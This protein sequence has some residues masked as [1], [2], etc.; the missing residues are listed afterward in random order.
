MFSGRWKENLQEVVELKELSPKTFQY[1]LSFIYSN[2]IEVSTDLDITEVLYIAD[3]YGING[4]KS[5]ISF[6]LKANYC[7]F[8]IA[9]YDITIQGAIKSLEIAK[10]FSLDDH[11]TDC[12]VWFIKHYVKIFANRNFAKASDDVKNYILSKIKKDEELFISYGDKGSHNF[13]LHY[14]FML[15]P[16]LDDFPSFFDLI[17]GDPLIEFKVNEFKM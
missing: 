5:A 3:M 15:K 14:G 10:I 6:H 12:Y 17:S 16:T 2:K 1:I 9:S 4:I 8:F 11:L 7:Y 13:M